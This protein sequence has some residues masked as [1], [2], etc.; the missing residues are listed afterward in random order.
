MILGT[1]S[2]IFVPMKTPGLIIVDEEHD[3]SLKQQEGLRYS[4]RDLAIV[5]AKKQDIPVVLGSA[6]REGP[7]AFGAYGYSTACSLARRPTWIG[8]SDSWNPVCHFRAD[9]NAGSYYCR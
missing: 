2:A 5:R 4:A 9:E 8:S 1:R 6:T 3:S 7:A